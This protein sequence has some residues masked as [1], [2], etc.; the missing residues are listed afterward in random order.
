MKAFRN[1]LKGLRETKDLGSKGEDIAA[2][3]LKKKGYKIITRNYK[4]NAGEID[5]IAQHGETVVFIE[6]KTRADY[7]FGYPYEAVHYRKRE[8]LKNLALLYMKKIGREVPIRFDVLSIVKNSNEKFE[9]QHI[10][11]AFE[12]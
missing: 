4:T 6:V 1:F 10:I 7:S 11:D 3:Y 12:V 2:G 8:K 5:I 9:I